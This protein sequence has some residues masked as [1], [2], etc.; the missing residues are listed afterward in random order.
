[1]DYYS[2]VHSYGATA[3]EMIWPTSQ[4]D[5]DPVALH[6]ADDRRSHD[7][8]PWLAVNMIATVD[9]AA[10][11]AQGLTGNL[12]GPGD[13]AVFSALRA[14]ADVIVAGAGTVIAE[15][16]GPSRPRAEVVAQRV[17][18]GQQPR[19]RIAVVTGSLAIEPDR[20]LFRDATDEARPIILT[21]ARAEATRRRALEA[22]ADVH[23]AGDDRVD[24]PAAIDVLGSLGAG[25]VLCEGGPITNAGLIEH[26]LI[27]EMCLT[28]AP[29]L[30]A[31][32]ATRIVEGPAPTAPR[33]LS[34][35]RV[36]VEDGFLFLR[37]TRAKT[38]DD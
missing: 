23:T 32:P 16:Y 2:A 6:A 15:D 33:G 14:V 25:I 17:A 13:R 24:W 1:M 38:A 27:D 9:G 31:G 5:V 11:D 10:A 8:R 7:G 29:A 36:L 20:R 30:V 4:G 21:T 37:Y 34:L 35:D 3:M 12:G 28:V 19:P 18:R 22:V 26:D